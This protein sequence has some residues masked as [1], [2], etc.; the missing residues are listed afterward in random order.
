MYKKFEKKILL[1]ICVIPLL[2]SACSYKELE[3]SLKRKL[4]TDEDQYV[5]DTKIPDEN[6]ETT[7]E[8][9]K[10]YTIGDTVRYSFE[11]EEAGTY[12]YTLN[13]VQLSDNIH[14]AGLTNSDFIEQTG[15][16]KDGNIDSENQLLT[17]D[18]TVKNIN[19]DGKDPTEKVPIV[20]IQPTISFKSWIED[21]DG[22]WQLYVDYFSHGIVLY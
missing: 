15:F 12:E 5:N 10:V 3:D 13:D 11:V 21:P 17:L 7:E 22:P 14:D 16:D 19:S 8:E 18:F 9:K 2:L 4:N 1:L 6:S 20:P